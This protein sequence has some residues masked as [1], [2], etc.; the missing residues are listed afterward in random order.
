MHEPVTEK[1]AQR[2]RTLVTLAQC[3]RL[4]Y[5]RAIMKRET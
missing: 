2:A 1:S 5:D 3:D 4:A